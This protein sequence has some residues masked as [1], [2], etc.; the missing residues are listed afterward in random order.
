[1]RGKPTS[2]ETAI[3]WFRAARNIFVNGNSQQIAPLWVEVLSL[4][5]APSTA[6]ASRSAIDR[7]AWCARAAHPTKAWNKNALPLLML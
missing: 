3:E 6:L 7:A 1:L 2:Y 5:R 4:L